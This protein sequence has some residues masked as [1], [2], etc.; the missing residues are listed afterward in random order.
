MTSIIV[1]EILTHY[2]GFFNVVIFKI[3]ECANVMN[4]EIKRSCFLPNKMH[5]LKK[6]YTKARIFH[7][8]ILNVSCSVLVL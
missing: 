3:Y 8:Y 4:A 7:K 1:F 6:T 5:W 2:I